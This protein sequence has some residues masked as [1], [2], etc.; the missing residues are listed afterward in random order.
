MTG[1]SQNSQVPADSCNLIDDEL[2]DNLDQVNQDVDMLEEI[3]AN[4]EER[5]PNF[6]R[7]IRTTARRHTSLISRRMKKAPAKTIETLCLKFAAMT[8]MVVTNSMATRDLI[9]FGKQFDMN[10]FNSDNHESDFLFPEME[11][12]D[13]LN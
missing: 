11:D 2:L 3:I 6:A 4:L 1:K 8:Y 13:D 5:E 12:D 10:E 9:E 7:W